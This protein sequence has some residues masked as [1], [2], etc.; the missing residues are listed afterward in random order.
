MCLR[1]FG[2]MR[3]INPIAGGRLGLVRTLRIVLFS[4]DMSLQD[5]AIIPCRAIFR[6]HPE[7]LVQLCYR[8]QLCATNPSEILQDSRRIAS[9]WQLGLAVMYAVHVSLQDYFRST[10]I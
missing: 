7:D 8:P 5:T 6:T 3:A 10:G 9:I 4:I 2:P 1:L